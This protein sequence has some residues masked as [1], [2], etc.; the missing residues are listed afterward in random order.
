MT[1]PERRHYEQRCKDKRTGLDM[2]PSDIAQAVD[3][4]DHQPRQ[5]QRDE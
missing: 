4:R 2:V 3:E 1:K 5:A